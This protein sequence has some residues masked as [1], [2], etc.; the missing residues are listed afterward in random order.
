MKVV[1]TVLGGSGAV[2]PGCGGS[3]KPDSSFCGH[4]GKL[5]DLK[6]GRVRTPEEITDEDL[7]EIL[8][9]S[10]EAEQ[11]YENSENCRRANRSI[12]IV[13]IGFILCFTVVL[14]PIG[15]CMAVYGV[16]RGAIAGKMP[17]GYLEPGEVERLLQNYLLPRVMAEPFGQMG[18]YQP[19]KRLPAT[20]IHDADL[21]QAPYNIMRGK[22]YYRTVYREMPLQSSAVILKNRP[23][24]DAEDRTVT[25]VFEGYFTVCDT[26]RPLDGSVLVRE[27]VAGED[28]KT[29]IPVGHTEFDR[30]FSVEASDPASVHGVLTPQRIEL[31]LEL[32]QATSG[33]LTVRFH[34]GGRISVAEEGLEE[35]FGR[36]KTQETVAQTRVRFRKE[37]HCPAQMLALF[38][39]ARE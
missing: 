10:A 26:G 38:A 36:S 11:A 24:E 23:P 7:Q 18:E 31:L 21:V 17:R 12:W 37:M 3:V 28:P 30:G 2:C 39:D 27:R 35:R 22:E 34:P 19:D 15:V 29:G 8:R 25:P 6:N 5:I 33:R 16:I 13:V 20:V 32:R 4:C 1:T 14:M 9:V